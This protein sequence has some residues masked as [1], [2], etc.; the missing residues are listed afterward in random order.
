MG[1]LLKYEFCRSRTIF[2]G[3]IGV[4]LLI[5]LVY[6]IGFFTKIKALFAVG[7]TGGILC[8]ALGAAAILLYGVIMFNDDISK[9]PGYLLFSRRAAPHRSWAQSF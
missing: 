7:L 3:I 9:K 1:T 6:L 4:T 8:L 2:L 5:E